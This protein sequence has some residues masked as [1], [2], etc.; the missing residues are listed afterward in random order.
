MYLI[1]KVKTVIDGNTVA[2]DPVRLCLTRRGAEKHCPTLECFYIEDVGF[3][4]IP[5]NPK[6]IFPRAVSR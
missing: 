4:P 2:W 5:E 6:M 3:K 1:G